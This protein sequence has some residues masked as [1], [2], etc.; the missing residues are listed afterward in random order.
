MIGNSDRRR[1]RKV[2]YDLGQFVPTLNFF[3][4]MYSHVRVCEG[5][6]LIY[7]QASAY[8]YK[9]TTCVLWALHRPSYCVRSWLS[10]SLSLFSSLASFIC[11]SDETNENKALQNS[12]QWHTVYTWPVARRDVATTQGENIGV[13]VVSVCTYFSLS[14]NQQRENSKTG[15]MDTKVELHNVHGVSEPQFLFTRYIVETCKFKGE[16]NFP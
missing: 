10:C 12:Y 8:T 1:Q 2:C 4:W 15:R 6:V 14:T 13:A 16:A 5:A 7:S 9:V 11:F 3:L